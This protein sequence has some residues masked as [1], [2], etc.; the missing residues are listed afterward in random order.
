[1]RNSFGSYQNYLLVGGKSEIGKALMSEYMKEGYVKRIAII[2][3]DGSTHAEEFG[4]YLLN[5]PADQVKIFSFRNHIDFMSSLEDAY[6]FLQQMDVLLLCTGYL[7]RLMNSEESLSNCRDAN[8]ILPSSAALWASLKMRLQGFGQ[9]IHISSI[10][11]AR[12]RPDNWMYGSAKI[13]MDFFLEGLRHEIVGTNID[14]LNVR[15]G[16]VKTKMSKH[17]PEAPFTVE[18][19][20]IAQYIIRQKKTHRPLWYPKIMRYISLILKLL[21]QTIVNRMSINRTK[22]NSE[23]R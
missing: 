12:P 17:L 6:H 13:A 2:Y 5:F 22:S 20:Q 18:T 23:V 7:P 11:I 21:P 10:A 1:M 4:E 16:M 9:I 19:S 14:I 8:Y 15:T 3:R